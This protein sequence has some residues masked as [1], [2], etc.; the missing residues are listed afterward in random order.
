MV[1]ES[2]VA[3]SD[4]AVAVAE[5]VADADGAL[6]SDADDATAEAYDGREYV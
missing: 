5:G 1:L 4:E 3:V 6:D 2:V